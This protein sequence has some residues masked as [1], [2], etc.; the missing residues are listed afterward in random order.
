MGVAN[1]NEWAS[2]LRRAVLNEEETVPHGFI[3]ARQV[4]AK[5]GLGPTRTSEVLLK[6]IRAGLA[7]KGVFRVK[8]QSGVVRPIP[9][10]RLFTASMKTPSSRAACPRIASQ[11]QTRSG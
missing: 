8:T 5:I 1:V 3:T 4:A 6:M 9:H 11:T 7:E 10:Y 2:A